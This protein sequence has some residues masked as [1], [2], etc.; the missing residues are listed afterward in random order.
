MARI[1]KCFSIDKKVYNGLRKYLGEHKE[2]R[3]MS[4]L[5]EYAL[6]K[7]LEEESRKHG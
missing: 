1:V 4:H 2:F 6:R 3:N 7:F 5:V